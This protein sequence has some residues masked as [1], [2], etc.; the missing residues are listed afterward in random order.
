MLRALEHRGPDGEGRYQGRQ[1]VMGMRRLAIVDPLHGH[2]PYRSESGHLVAVYNGEI[3]NYPELRREM[4]ARGHT[5]ASDADGEVLVHL[6]EE[7]GADF[8]THLRGMYALA[9]WDEREGVLLLARDRTGQKPLYLWEHGQTVAFASELK[10]LMALEEFAPQ[11]DV[12]QLSTYLAHRFVPAPLTMLK[13]VTKL[14]PG[15]A[16]RLYADGRRQRWFY[17]QPALEAIDESISAEQWEERLDALLEETV[18]EHLMA[19]VPVG[20]FLSGG[21]DSSLLAAAAARHYPGTLDA[22]SAAFGADYPGYDESA[23]AQRVAD[24]FGIRLHPVDVEWVITAERLAELAYVLDEPMADPTVLPLDGLARHAAQSHRVVLSGEGADEIFAGYAG[25]GE[26]ASLSRLKYLPAPLRRWWARLDWPGSGAARRSLIP[27]AERYR[28]VG[29]TFSP[30]QQDRLLWDPLRGSDR[31]AAVSEYWNHARSLPELQAMQG[32]DIR[33]FLPDD[34]LLKADRIGMHYHLEI[35]VPYCD[36]RLVELALAIPVQWRRR[37]GEGKY[38]LRRVAQR[39]LPRPVAQR[40]KRGFPTP[41]T[42]L[43]TGRLRAVAWETLTDP[44]ALIRQWVNPAEV[45]RWLGALDVRGPAASRQIYALLML[46]LWSQEM[47]AH[48]QRARRV[49]TRL[50]PRP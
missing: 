21:L 35:R 30:E 10:G 47:V 34:V 32:F 31:T 5:L 40:K 13:D 4:L 7:Y 37:G 43:L 9:L 27:L 16:M 26:A 14:E 3:Y 39:R 19:D 11:I 15:E 6:Y 49:T 36:H 50:L 41:L 48:R 24:Q 2:Q 8:L 18:A 23:W 1:L 28:G 46:E 20:L 38:F 45:E 17:W 29:F 44:G 33:W 42:D 25:Y 12:R 22:W